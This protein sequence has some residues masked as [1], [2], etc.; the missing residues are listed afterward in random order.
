MGEKVSVF[1][2]TKALFV[3]KM[4][5]VNDEINEIMGDV[6]RGE[7]GEVLYPTPFYFDF[8]DVMALN[9]SCYEGYTSIRF[10][11]DYSYTVKLNYKEAKE[12]FRKSRGINVEAIS[13]A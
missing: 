5:D 10:F 11:G 8:S 3:T 4:P 6:I 9:P 13:I 1:V 7:D 12:L 2:E